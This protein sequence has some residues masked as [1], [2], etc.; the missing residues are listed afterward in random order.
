MTRKF[1]TAVLIALALDA[2]ATGYG[3]VAAGQEARSTCT[4]DHAVV[5]AGQ[6]VKDGHV[7]FG[8]P[9]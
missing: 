6:C 4:Q 9:L 1:A 8:V 5:Q 7:L 3:A 2:L